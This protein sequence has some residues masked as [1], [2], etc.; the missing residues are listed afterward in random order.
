VIEVGE[1]SAVSDREVKIPR[2]ARAVV[3]E[4]WLIDLNDQIVEVYRDPGEGEYRDRRKVA[5]GERLSPQ[6]LQGV[7]VDV[8]DILG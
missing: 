8:D 3:P 4:V 2:Y 7:K 1:S 6:A 5:R